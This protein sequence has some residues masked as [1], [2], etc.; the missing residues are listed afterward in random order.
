MIRLKQIEKKNND[1]TCLGYIEDCDEPVFIHIDA[2]TSEVE[3]SPFPKGYEYETH[4]AMA[5]FA[6]MEIVKKGDQLPKE[7]LVMWY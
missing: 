2:I 4:I 5:R 7:K 3:H 1:I 6:L